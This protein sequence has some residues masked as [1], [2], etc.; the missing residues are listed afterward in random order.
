MTEG[1]EARARKLKEREEVS[2]KGGKVETGTQTA[3]NQPE[4]NPDWEISKWI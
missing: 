2:E 4:I 1:L 3:A